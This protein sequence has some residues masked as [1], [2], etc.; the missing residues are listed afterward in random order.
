MLEALIVVALITVFIGLKLLVPRWLVGKAVKP[1]IILF[2]K[3]GAVSPQSAKSAKELGIGAMNFAQRMV[4]PRDYRP[5]ALEVLMQTD[6]V[7]A[8]DEGK[9]YLSKEQLAKTPMGQELQE[10]ARKLREEEGE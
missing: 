7:L 5:K 3:H 8:T 2:L 4:R 1:V 6:I 10:E 9:L